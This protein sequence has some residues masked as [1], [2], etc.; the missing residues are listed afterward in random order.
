MPPDL[1]SMSNHAKILIVEDQYFVAIDNEMNLTAAGFDCV[2]LASNADDAFELA[3]RCKPD[4]VLMDIRLAGRED[5]V[6]AAV[7]IYRELGIRCIFTSGHADGVIRD[8]AQEAHPL[9]WLNKPYSNAE[10]VGA[11]KSGLT[12]LGHRSHEHGHCAAS[13]DLH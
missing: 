7:E 10:L 3:C 13:R 4:L 8:Q 6:H 2:G 1:S 12:E 5:G 11:V 9:G